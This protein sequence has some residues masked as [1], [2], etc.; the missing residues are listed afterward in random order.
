MGRGGGRATDL[1]DSER[2]MH[3]SYI[4][5]FTT[6]NAPDMDVSHGAC[7]K[8]DFSFQLHVLD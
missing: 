3:P 6:D 5:P 1:S 7:R 8:G 4:R 2:R